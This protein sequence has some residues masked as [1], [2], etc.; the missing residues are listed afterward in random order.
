MM[1]S[2]SGIG[3]TPLSDAIGAEV[4]GIDLSEPLDAA[5]VETLKQGWYRHVVLVFRGQS[6]SND[7]Q[8]RFCRAFG[9]LEVVRS[10]KYANADMKHTMMITNVRDT[11]MV[12]ALEDGD[13]WFHADQCYYE[14]PA[15][16]SMLYAMEIPPYGGN[17]LFANAYLAWETLPA[18][19]RTRLESRR[20]HHIY[21]Y[22][23]NPTKRGDTIDP[24]A[25]QHLHP[26]A[27]T[28]PETG[29]KALYVNRLMT[30]Y[31]E[32]LPQAESDALLAGLFE[33]IEDRRFVYEH[34]WQVGDLVMWDNRCSTHARTDFDPQARRMLRRITVKGEAVL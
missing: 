8:V 21:D 24:D 20:A 4:T 19:L 6:L 13:M 27:R 18:D 2:V 12:T 26:V 5:T 28:H 33:H 14:V 9:D 30:D 16:A 22:S 11:G 32:G 3:F 23:G 25:P 10:G 29:R 17:T 34:V 1:V 15:R 7:D 31:I